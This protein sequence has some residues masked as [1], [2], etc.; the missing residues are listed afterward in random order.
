[1]VT[2][3]QGRCLSWFRAVAAVAIVSRVGFV[4]EAPQHDQVDEAAIPALLSQVTA[5]DRQGRQTGL[6]DREPG[7]DMECWASQGAQCSQA[8][9]SL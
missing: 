2:Q 3:L 5:R 6:G 1:M 7:Q 8:F 4:L 9:S